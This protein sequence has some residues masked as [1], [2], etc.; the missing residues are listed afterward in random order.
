ML[1][2]RQAGAQTII[3]LRQGGFDGD[4]TLIGEEKELPYQRPPLSKKFLSGEM[5]AERLFFRPAEFYEKE[6]ITVKLS[7]RAETIDRNAKTLTLDDG[8]TL[9]MTN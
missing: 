5:P 4:I 6:N 2:Y 3:S 9:P 1:L 8:G 7:C